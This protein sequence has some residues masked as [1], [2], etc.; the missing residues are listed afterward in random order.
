MV[1]ENGL[2]RSDPRVLIRTNEA[3]QLA[4]TMRDKDGTPIIPV[5][6]MMIAEVDV[7]EDIFFL[8]P[9][10]ETAFYLEP[11]EGMPGT[12]NDIEDVRQGFY[13]VVNPATYVDP[14]MAYD[15]PFTD[16][17]LSSELAMDKLQRK[18]K[19]PGAGTT[20]ILVIGRKAYVPMTGDD[21]ELIVQNVPALK[22]LIQY[23][24][25]DENNQATEA[26]MRYD[27]AR[28]LL[29]GEIKGHQM[30]PRWIMKRKGDYER[31]LRTFVVGSKGWTRARIALEA[32]GAME[33]GKSEIGRA[34]DRAQLRMIEGGTFKGTLEEFNA[35]ITDGH[36]YCPSRV[37][38]VYGATLGCNPIDIRSMF[39]KYQQNGPGNHDW[40]CGGL[41]S[42]EG[43]RFFPGEGKYR[44]VYR[45][46]VGTSGSPL[47]MVCKLKWEPKKATDQLTIRNFEANR[48]MVSAILME[49]AEKWTE[50]NA[51][52]STVLGKDGILQKELNEYLA[53]IKHTIPFAADNTFSM[54][55][56]GH[57]F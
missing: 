53:G 19:F 5:N 30:D 26:A 22:A 18:Y 3:V 31:D 41:L 39:F 28:E 12:V 27:R 14:S 48:V 52:V 29:L 44:R 56:L 20:R 21:D 54:N 57:V 55:D 10:M 40:S 4:L 50:A 35:T 45:A 37:E 32:P 16:M 17:F 49:A 7:V 2:D 11:D 1:C 24:E 42:D 23:A 38:S 47:T 34:I 9:E 46:M 25:Y 51:A 36:I 15:N 13:N 8:P 33:V 43:E 6:S